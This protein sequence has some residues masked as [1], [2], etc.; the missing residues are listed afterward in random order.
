MWWPP[1]LPVQE[2]V[3]VVLNVAL[4][5]RPTQITCVEYE[6]RTPL[7]AELVDVERSGTRDWA[8]YTAAVLRFVKPEQRGKSFRWR[9]IEKA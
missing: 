4:Q 6:T 7:D 2:T 9:V 1:G 3:R 5:K 8:R